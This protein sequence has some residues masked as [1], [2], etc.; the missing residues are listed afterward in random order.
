MG[1][2][3]IATDVA[4]CRD[5]VEDGV[6]GFLCEAHDVISLA[7]VMRRLAET[8]SMELRK[9]G[10]ASRSLVEERFDERFVLRAYLEEL[11]KVGLHAEAERG[12]I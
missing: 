12:S 5:V 7:T 2:P 11:A 8:S 6:N 3:L 1:R 4:G 9:M 10:A